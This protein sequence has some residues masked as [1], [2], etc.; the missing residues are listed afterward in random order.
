MELF[1]QLFCHQRQTD[2]AWPYQFWFTVV[3]HF[4]LTYSRCI[5]NCVCILPVVVVV[6]EDDCTSEYRH[7]FVTD[8]VSIF[9]YTYTSFMCTHLFLSIC[10][11]IKSSQF[12][13]LLNVPFPRQVSTVWYPDL[14]VR[15]GLTRQVWVTNADSS[16]VKSMNACGSVHFQ[17]WPNS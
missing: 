4:S 14:S 7:S 12:G 3:G 6:R 10:P 5:H 17:P 16:S 1:V 8:E 13:E 15:T 2:L 11:H 9:F